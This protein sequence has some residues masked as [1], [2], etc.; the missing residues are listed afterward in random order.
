MIQTTRIM[1]FV[2]LN[3]IP[4]SIFTVN[5]QNELVLERTLLKTHIGVY[6]RILTKDN[7]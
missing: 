4:D 5:F 7:N 3:V 6:L 1:L 2:P